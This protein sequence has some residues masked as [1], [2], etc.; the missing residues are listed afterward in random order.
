VV[1]IFDPPGH[2]WEI[3]LVVLHETL[4]KT[5][6]VINVPPP[7]IPPF[8]KNFESANISP[9]GLSS[10]F[11]TIENICII[12]LWHHLVIPVGHFRE[13]GNPIFYSPSGYPLSQAVAGMTPSSLCTNTKDLKMSCTFNNEFNSKGH[14]RIHPS[15]YHDG[16]IRDFPLN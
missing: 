13:N 8:K 7:R 4:T 15:G 2:L 16:L 6:S 5:S 11:S 1:L 10:L 9:S 12:H 14:T 3:L